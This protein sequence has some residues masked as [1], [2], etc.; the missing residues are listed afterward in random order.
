MRIDEQGL[1]EALAA[2]RAEHEAARTAEFAAWQAS[3]PEAVGLSIAEQEVLV[4]REWF[5]TEYP[6]AAADPVALEHAAWQQPLYLREAQACVALAQALLD[7]AAFRAAQEEEIEER[8]QTLRDAGMEAED[9]S[10][11]TS[12]ALQVMSW[13]TTLTEWRWLPVAERFGGQVAAEMRTIDLLNLLN[14]AFEMGDEERETREALTT[15]MELTGDAARLR[16]L[17][18][19]P[20]NEPED[21]A[22]ASDAPGGDA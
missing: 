8:Q 11:Y 20:D 4:K 2:S 15:R 6:A 14:L 3:H 21:G 19:V 16:R 1:A 17:Y 7:F 13:K 9:V 22:D 10:A 18:A 5:V 12:G